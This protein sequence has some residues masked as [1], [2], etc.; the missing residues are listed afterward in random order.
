MLRFIS[1]ENLQRS[2]GGED[3][4]EYKYI[5]PVPGENKLMSEKEKRASIEMDQQDLIREF[6]QQTI[7]WVAID[8]GLSDTKAKLAKRHELAKQLRANFWDLDLYM[9]A[10]TYYHRAG[11]VGPEGQ[12]N[13]KAA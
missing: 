7:E 6:Q 11:V 13:F 8:P 10:R 1:K 4:W 9:R 3:H 2:Y 5:E 12:V